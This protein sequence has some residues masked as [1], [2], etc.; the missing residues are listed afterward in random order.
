MIIMSEHLCRCWNNPPAKFTSSSSSAFPRFSLDSPFW[1][2][3]F[4]VCDR[5]CCLFK[6]SSAVQTSVHTCLS[7]RTYVLIIRKCMH[8]PKHVSVILLIT[9]WM[10]IYQRSYIDLHKHARAH[11]PIYT[12]VHASTHIHTYFCA[13]HRCSPFLYLCAH[14]QS[15]NKPNRLK[16][17]QRGSMILFIISFLLLF[18]L[19]FPIFLF[20]TC[21]W[22]LLRETNGEENQWL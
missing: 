14:A 20:R 6:S 9:T 22:Q 8:V 11:K 13:S 17:D 7:F 16:S 2:R 10:L 3:F 1:V 18:F 12:P 19:F 15:I 4:C 21:V 5:F